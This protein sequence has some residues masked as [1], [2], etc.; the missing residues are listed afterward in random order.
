MLNQSNVCVDLPGK[1]LYNREEEI[2]LEGG[3]MDGFV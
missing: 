3:V 1:I 2:T